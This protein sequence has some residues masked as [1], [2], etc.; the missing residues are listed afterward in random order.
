MMNTIRDAVDV[1]R[2]SRRDYGPLRGWDIAKT[3]LGF[4]RAYRRVSRGGNEPK[5]PILLHGHEVHFP[6]G[7]FANLH[8]LYREIFI[9]Q[10]YRTELPASPRILDAGAN[11]GLASVYWSLVYPNARVTAFEPAPSCLPHLKS[12]IG[13]KENVEIVEAAVGP[14]KGSLALPIEADNPASLRSGFSR[15]YSNVVDVDVVQLSD[16]VDESIDLAKIDVEGFETSVLRELAAAGVL[17]KI[18][19]FTIEYHHHLVDRADELDRLIG[20]LRDEGYDY[21]VVSG[22][23]VEVLVIYAWR[24]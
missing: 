21:R 2:I 4:E 17:P 9:D 12:N 10:T 18:K 16:Y 7:G 15:N 19:R 24:V 6:K 11:I 8:Y 20:L 1:V 14:E 5:S 3:W 22:D 23:E 13:W